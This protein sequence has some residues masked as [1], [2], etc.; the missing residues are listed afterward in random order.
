MVL[1]V[2]KFCFALIV[3]LLLLV[4]CG[5]EPFS[6]VLV[7]KVIVPEGIIWIPMQIGDST[8]LMPMPDP[9]KYYLEFQ[10]DDGKMRSVLSTKAA[11]DDAVIGNRYS[12]S[13]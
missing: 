12:Y 2:K 10:L 9:P 1:T 5:G 7:N 11:F 6:G 8:M 3:C 4:G 13:K